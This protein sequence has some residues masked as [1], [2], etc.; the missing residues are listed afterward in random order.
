MTLTMLFVMGGTAAVAAP[1]VQSDAMQSELISSTNVPMKVVGFDSKVAA[2]H[3][4]AIRRD[5]KGR[6]TS[7]PVGQSKFRVHTGFGVSS[8]AINYT[9]HVNV[10]GP[11]YNDTPRWRG[12]LFFTSTWEANHCADA[13]TRGT[14]SAKARGETTL[15]NGSVCSSL[16]PISNQPIF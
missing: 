14:Y 6:L 8:R 16:G 5:S 12:G 9:W 7:V 13:T 2:A 1:A 15:F 3:G 11:R 10:V 4:F